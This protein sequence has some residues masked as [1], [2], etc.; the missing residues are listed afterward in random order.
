LSSPAGDRPRSGLANV[1]WSE[2]LG[3]GGETP[4]KNLCLGVRAI[5][6]KVMLRDFELHPVEVVLASYCLH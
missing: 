2:G 6:T 5:V 3:R 1:R 4:A